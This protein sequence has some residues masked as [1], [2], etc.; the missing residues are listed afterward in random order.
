[1]FLHYIFTYP[2]NNIHGTE[3]KPN[4]FQ[5]PFYYISAK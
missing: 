2:R 3:L 4:F 5:F 1:M